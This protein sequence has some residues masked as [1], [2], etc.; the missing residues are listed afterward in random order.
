[1]NDGVRIIKGG[2][3]GSPQSLPAGRGEQTGPQR[4]REIA[5]TVQGWI[6]ES[7]RRRRAEEQ[8]AFARLNRSRCIHG[9][10]VS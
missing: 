6:A 7:A 4:E 1:M 3:A 10:I 5:G 9:E 2:R 8:L